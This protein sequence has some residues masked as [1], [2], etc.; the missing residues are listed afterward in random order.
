MNKDQ[1]HL[2][3]AQ[4][5]KKIAHL[6]GAKDI[7]FPGE[8]WVYALRTALGMSLR[9][10]G[11]RL[12]ITPQGTK[13]IERREK[14]GSI[15]LQ[16]LREVAAALDM[17]LV[18]GLVPNDQTLEKMIE[19]RAHELAREVVLKTSHTMHLE[20]QGLDDE[21]VKTAIEKR[22]EKFKNELPKHLWN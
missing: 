5:D 3:I 17:Q 18:Y 6:A 14:D 22:A 4:L 21:A 16:R 13:D 7:A 9:Q 8:G 19:K 20:N 1:K 15:T 10:L 12:G 11:N 2:R